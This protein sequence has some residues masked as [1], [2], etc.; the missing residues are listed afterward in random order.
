MNPRDVAD[1]PERK[2]RKLD[3]HVEKTLYSQLSETCGMEYRHQ[4]RMVEQAQ[5]WFWTDERL[6]EEA[7]GLQM[8]GCVRLQALNERAKAQ[9]GVRW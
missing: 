2:W 1:W 7:R 6:M 8:P 5:G 4:Q 3:S 9:G